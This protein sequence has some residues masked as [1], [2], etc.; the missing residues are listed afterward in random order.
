MAR[1][2][3]DILY[4]RVSGKL[5]NVVYRQVNGKTIICKAPKK[6]GK[7]K[8][9]TSIKLTNNFSKATKLTG[10]IINVSEIKSYYEEKFKYGK[11]PRGRVMSHL[12]KIFNDPEYKGVIL[13]PAIECMRVE[14]IEAKDKTNIKLDMKQLANEVSA[15]SLKSEIKILIFD[16]YIHTSGAIEIKTVT[17]MAIIDETGMITINKNHQYGEEYKYETGIAIMI[18]KDHQG[19]YKKYIQFMR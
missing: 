8:S 9:E 1:L 7:N 13:L 17:E 12:I 10:R 11:S 14:K 2:L 15:E 6:R 18:L 3:I 4:G 16:L 5:G 19:E